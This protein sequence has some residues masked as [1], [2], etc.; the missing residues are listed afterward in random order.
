MELKKWKE[1]KREEKQLWWCVQISIWFGN[2]RFSVAQSQRQKHR[3]A[4]RV[5][6]IQKTS[7]T[8]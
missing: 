7:N 6:E 3:Q 4:V 2:T 8:N 5:E 1:I